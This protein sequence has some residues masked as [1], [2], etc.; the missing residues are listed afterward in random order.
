MDMKVLVEASELEKVNPAHM[1]KM[2]VV[3]NS[4]DRKWVADKTGE[5]KK[6]MLT[7]L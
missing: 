2:K 1:Q 7:R 6:F 3:F 5:E 4:G